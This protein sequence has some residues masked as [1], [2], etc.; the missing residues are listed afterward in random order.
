MSTELAQVLEDA[1]NFQ[2]GLNAFD[3]TDFARKCPSTELIFA[4]I[5]NPDSEYDDDGVSS[6]SPEF[7]NDVATYLNVRDYIT[8][9]A[10][11]GAR[12]AINGGNRFC[13]LEGIAYLGDLEGGRTYDIRIYE[14]SHLT[15]N[16]DT[17][18]NDTITIPIVDNI[19]LAG[20]VA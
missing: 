19:P 4:E 2:Q 14:G 13:D 6:S 1:K 9:E 11:T 3:S 16:T 18:I 20:G 8:D 10:L 5:I 15:S 7:G 12:V 17:L